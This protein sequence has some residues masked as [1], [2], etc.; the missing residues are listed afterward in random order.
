MC[1][2]IYNQDGLSPVCALKGAGEAMSGQDTH[3]NPT[4]GLLKGVLDTC[5]KALIWSDSPDLL[6]VARGS[7]SVGA[8]SPV[9]AT[10][11]LGPAS[12]VPVAVP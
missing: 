9:Q 7:R 5:P 12:A 2:E 8:V 1:W 6:A 10:C 4:A 3:T 11:H